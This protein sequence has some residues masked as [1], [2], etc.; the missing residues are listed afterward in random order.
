[1][2]PWIQVTT[3]KKGERN[4][5]LIT[6]KVATWTSGFLLIAIALLYTINAF[7]EDLSPEAKSLLVE[8][9]NP[10]NPEE[11]LY[12]ALLGF[13]RLPGVSAVV[14]S[15]ERFAAY[16]KDIEKFLADPR[17]KF[18]DFYEQKRPKLAF[19]GKVDFCRPLT[20]SC[21]EGVETHSAEIRRLLKANGELMRRYSKLSQTRGYYETAAVDPDTYVL[22][23]YAPPVVRQAYLA[24]VALRVRT[25]SSE[26]RGAAV[27][28]LRDD[29]AVWRR[30]LV[31][32]GPL[33]AKMVAVANLQGDLVLLGDIL[34]DPRF[35]LRSHSAAIRAALDPFEEADWKIGSVQRN[36]FR[37][38]ITLLERDLARNGSKWLDSDPENNGWWKR[39]LDWLSRPFL[40][41]RATE[42]LLAKLAVQRRAI[43][44]AEPL[45]LFAAQD[46][47]QRWFDDNLAFGLHYAYNPLGKIL[48]AVASTPY[49]DYSLRAYDCAA[50]LRLV[51][52]AYAIRAQRVADQAIPAFMKQHPEW[53]THAVDG[54]AFIWDGKK[55][56]IAVQPLGKQPKERRFYVPVWGPESSR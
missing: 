53:S 37:L 32:N 30:M 3:G 52:L 43:A 42:N 45:R 27:R 4:I 9:P 13:D 1:L 22:V 15:E 14:A 56:E 48:A 17:H 44:D 10:Y 46:E 55:R 38:T 35:D 33:V 29:L 49:T 8:P 19:E 24:N 36:E 41:L 39:L 11:N 50:L 23:A 5:W 21:L 47:Y 28:N 7:D 12:Y 34:A 51:R 16:K 25:G 40:K 18:E 31:G 54:R 20:K 26:E 6:K 2:E